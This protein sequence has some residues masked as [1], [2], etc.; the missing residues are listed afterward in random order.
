M[1][2]HLI[3]GNGAAGTTAAEQIRKHDPHAEITMITK[4][5][6]PLYSR[7]RIPE[8]LS[9]KI[10]EQALI[11]KD[12]PWHEQRNI[13]LI[14]ETIV[15]QINYK[16]KTAV[17]QEGTTF[18]YD[19][20]LLAT[21]SNSFIPPVKGSD[22]K[23]V[24]TLRTAAD[25]R[26][27]AAIDTNEKE[28]VLIGGGLLGLEAAAAMVS[29]GKRVTV[30]E[31]FD[32][33]LPRQ[34]DNEGAKR[35]QVLLENMGF[36]FR[37]GEIT[38]EIC[39][40]DRVE[41]VTLKSGETLKAHAVLFSA[42]VRSEMSLVAD[43]GIETDRGIVVNEQMETSLTGVYA[44]GDVAQFDDINFCIWPE[45]VEQGRVAGINMAGGQATFKNIP[46]SNVLKVAGIAL[47]SAGNIDVEGKMHSDIVATD[48]T[49]E[50]IVKNDDGTIIGCIMLGDTT[51]FN[52]ILKQ[53]KGD[54]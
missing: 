20:L 35:L 41:G 19:T 2:S 40:K 6:L 9:G 33:L 10:Q 36:A 54:Q 3:I 51:S 17:S 43:S 50:K 42:G 22:K 45:A 8:F 53:I 29:K 31:F 14:T 16:N 37:L 24:F 12:L 38:R 23:G 21:G 1:T 49:Y 18:S 13:N 47:A 34:L 26:A 11:I 5:S 52:K 7:I 25:A 30:V 27:L 28:M 44:A 15:S 39:G 48:T 32:R 4:E 46:P